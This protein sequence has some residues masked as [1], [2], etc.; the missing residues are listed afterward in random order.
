MTSPVIITVVHHP[1][2][3]VGASVLEAMV[4]HFDKIGMGR[5]GIHMRIPVRVRSEALRSD[6]LLEIVPEARRLDV[7][8]LLQS[9][10]LEPDSN[11]WKRLIEQMQDSSAAQPEKLFTQVVMMESGLQPSPSL[12]HLQAL[13]WHQW[14]GLDVAA[15]GRRLMIHLANSIRRRLPAKSGSEREPIFISHAKADGRIA[16]ERIIAYIQDPQNGL[17]LDTFYD[18]LQLEAGEAW[19]EGLKEGVA[20]GS[21]LALVSDAYD[22]RPWCNQEMLWAKKHRRPILLVD[23]GRRRV[24]RSFPYAGNVPLMAEPMTGG[25]GI[26][27]VLLELLSEAL[28]C[29]LFVA[30]VEEAAPGGAIAMPRPPE[31]CDLV[32]H[33]EEPED[34]C[35]VYPDPPLSD[36]ELVLLDGSGCGREVAVLS[37]LQ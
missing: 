24:G 30:E 11:P 14:T 17:K 27:A 34:R 12:A 13:Q 32:F 8:V 35:L 19:E 29:D 3:A 23:I 37:D 20:K 36:F 2:D 22:T 33:K 16:A 21:L 26:E 1:A 5:A 7:V 10:F 9:D 6:A 18:A 4:A 25:T 28:R 15:R 31:L